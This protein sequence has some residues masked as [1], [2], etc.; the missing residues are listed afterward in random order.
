[1]PQTN[2]T[3]YLLVR[4]TSINVDYLLP[5]Q[6]LGAECN[7]GGIDIYISPNLSQDNIKKVCAS[8][9]KIY[10]LMHSEMTGGLLRGAAIRIQHGRNIYWSRVADDPYNKGVY[11][12]VVDE[13]DLNKELPSAKNFTSMSGNQ[14]HAI[15]LATATKQY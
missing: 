5:I 6:S 8:T 14:T 2:Q 12:C 10:Y 13:N 15:S 4:G 3:R 9:G 1:M 7:Y 11:V